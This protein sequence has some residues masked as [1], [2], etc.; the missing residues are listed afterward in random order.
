MRAVVIDQL[1]QLVP[2]AGVNLVESISATTD[3]LHKIADE[4]QVHILLISH[5]NRTGDRSNAPSLEELK[6][7]GSIEQDA[8]LCVALWRDVDQDDEDYRAPLKLV[9][10]KNR[11]RGGLIGSSAELVFHD[12][13]RLTE[14]LQTQT[15]SLGL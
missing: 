2:R 1:Q 6:G 13:M 14:R 3:E 11:N 4:T 5:I 8:D 9:L 15:S 10:R 12:N 7:S